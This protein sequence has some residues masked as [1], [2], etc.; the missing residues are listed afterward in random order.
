MFGFV[1]NLLGVKADQAVRAG[2]EALVKWDPKAA[3]EAELLTMEQNLDELGR[4]VATA[5]IAY[6]KEAQEA[7]AIVALH[8][9]RMTAAEQLA[10]QAA[11]ESDPG[12]KAQIE[13]SLSTLLTMLEEMQPEVLREKQDAVEAKEFLDMLEASYNDAAAKLRE[14]RSVLS[15][16]Q[17]DMERAEQQRMAAERKEEV[18][19]RAAGLS[20]ASD[21]VG[22]ALRAMKEA[23]DKERIE[24]E[25]KLSKARMLATSKPEDDDPHI[26]AALAAA[27]GKSPAATDLASRLAALKKG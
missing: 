5:R 25:A 13:R 14:A 15:R 22:V 19:R 6:E 4:E 10:T 11:T 9:Q 26:K 12:R 8:G 2:V 20:G 23:A 7:Q 27:A 24:T 21:G 3:T 17:R 16:A 1:K 18:A